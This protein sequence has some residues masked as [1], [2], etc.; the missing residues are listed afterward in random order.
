MGS[1]TRAHSARAPIGSRHVL[2]R[3]GVHDQVERS[4]VKGQGRPCR[5]R[6][7]A[8]A[9]GPRSRDKPWAQRAG[10]VDLENPPTA[11][12]VSATYDS[13]VPASP[14]PAATAR[15]SACDRTLPPHRS[16]RVPCWTLM[17]STSS[18]LQLPGAD[19]LGPEH[20]RM[21]EPPWPQIW[22]VDRRQHHGAAATETSSIGMAINP[23]TTPVA[24]DRI[25]SAS[26]IQ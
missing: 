3:I 8:P 10:L 14:Q 20:V 4:I 13:S 24:T 15:A 5:P 6:D 2:E 11:P 12:A 19:E 23:F 26:W 7:I 21:H 1:R 25:T 16:Q 22:H 18:R 17:Y 9:G